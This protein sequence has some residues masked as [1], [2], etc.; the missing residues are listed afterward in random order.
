MKLARIFKARREG[1]AGG[2]AR[3][4]VPPNYRKAGAL[5][6]FRWMHGDLSILYA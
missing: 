6:R 4:R 1:Q 2:E 5:Y 3:V